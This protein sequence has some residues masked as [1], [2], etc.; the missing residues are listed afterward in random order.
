MLLINN[1]RSSQATIVV[2]TSSALERPKPSNIRIEPLT[3]QIGVPCA[4]TTIAATVD[5]AE[6]VCVVYSERGHTS[7]EVDTLPVRKANAGNV[8]VSLAAVCVIARLYIERC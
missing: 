5:R 8:L 6:A 1:F 4:S 2:A 3:I 7:R